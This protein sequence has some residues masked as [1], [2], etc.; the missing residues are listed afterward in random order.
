MSI[1]R[2]KKAEKHNE[3]SLKDLRF[4]HQ[5]VSPVVKLSLV[6]YVFMFPCVVWHCGKC[7]YY[8]YLCFFTAVH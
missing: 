2:G 6:L 3:K 5:N 1:E 8:T 7:A 4:Q